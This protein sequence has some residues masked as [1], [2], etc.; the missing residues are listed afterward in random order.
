VGNVSILTAQ[1]VLI[2]FRFG[3]SYTMTWGDYRGDRIAIFSYNELS[4]SG[5]VDIDWFHYDYNAKYQIPAAINPGTSDLTHMWTFDDGTSNDQIGSAHGILRGG[6]TIGNGALK[7]DALGQYLELPATQLGIKSYPAL[8]VEAWFKS[9]AG[10]NTGYTMLGYF[11]NT[12]NNM[13]SD[14]CYI[15]VARGDNVSRVGITC[16]NTSAPYNNES[17]ANATELDDGLLH[18]VVGV[19]SSDM[20]SIYEDGINI[21]TGSLLAGNSISN[22]ILNYAYLAKSGYSGDPTWLGSIDK[23]SLY[24]KA[25]SAGEVQ[26]LYQA[27]TATDVKMAKADEIKI[28]P[29]PAVDYISI[30]GISG[31]ANVEIFDLQGRVLL[32]IGNVISNQRIGLEG[33][34]SGS[35]LVRISTQ[36]ETVMK[37]ILHG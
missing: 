33:I 6:A 32:S 1:I 18:Q 10:T 19:I 14:G 11:G 16:G 15:S 2:I 8:S 34:A 30:W 36:D 12:V 20:V 17:F 24:N 26:Y 35:Y 3:S 13:G 27:G 21:S 25:L 5:L 22:I 9:K 28:F 31:N 4:E 29:N 23:F 7:T 37:K